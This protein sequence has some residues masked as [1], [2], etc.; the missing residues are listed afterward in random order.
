VRSRPTRLE[1]GSVYEGDVRVGYGF[2]EIRWGRRQNRTFNPRSAVTRR[3]DDGLTRSLRL[4]DTSSRW[5][6]QLCGRDRFVHNGR[7]RFRFQKLG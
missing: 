2:V 4:V 5:L 7:H 1:Q 6:D 3:Q